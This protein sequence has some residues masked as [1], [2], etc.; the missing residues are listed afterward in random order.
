MK[1][2]AK[3]SIEHIFG[4]DNIVIPLVD[5][6][7]REI[8]D[9]LV[10]ID[11]LDLDRDY[12]VKISENKRKRSL[13]ANSYLWVLL[14]KIANELSKQTPTKKEDIYRDFVR[15]YGTYEIVPIRKDAVKKWCENWGKNGVGWV[16]E[17][18]GKSKLDGYENIV[19]YYGSST[20]DTKEMARLINAV[21]DVCKEMKIETLTPDELE[22]LKQQW[23]QNS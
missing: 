10:S 2:R 12:S 19:C 1:L 21:V 4:Q 14:G 9:F 20:Y 8:R 11:E 16:C 13:D 17:S 3:P 23:R 18:L 15:D 6:Q 5:G 7:N 22:R